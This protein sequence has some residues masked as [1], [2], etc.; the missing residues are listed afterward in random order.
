MSTLRTSLSRAPLGVHLLFGALVA[1][2]FLLAGCS[3]EEPTAPPP[4]IVRTVSVEA[5]APPTASFSGVTRAAVE[6]QVSFQ[7]GGVVTAVPVEVGD[8]VRRG[9]LL[10]RLD[11]ADFELQAQQAASAL[12]QAEAQARAAA[13]DFDR[14]RALYAEGVIPAS[15]YDNARAR[16]ETTTS[17]VAAARDQV[18]LAQR[19]LGY[20]RLGAPV[21]GRVAEVFVEAGELV[22]PG[23]PVALV[24]TEDSP[25][26][27]E[28]TVPEQ[29]IGSIQE[30]ATAA[31]S[32]AALPGD[33]FT[34]TV[35]EVGV[36]SRRTATTFPVVLRVNEAD[37]R[38]RSGKTARVTFDLSTLD[39]AE[40]QASR[41][42]VLPV[43][44]IDA[45]T[46]GTYVMVIEPV[47]ADSANATSVS[48]RS[49]EEAVVRRRAVETGTLRSDGVEVL[50]GL[51]AHEW[52]VAAGLGELADGQRVRLAD[53]DPLARDLLSFSGR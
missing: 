33:T 12:Q 36:A 51:E 21:S 8:R 23:Q 45:D 52:V 46:E 28:V 1:L 15:Q 48:V 53:Y 43:A 40:A 47:V 32:F 24:N 6:S 13:A 42:L 11:A 22:G 19:G 27:V 41:A 4:P 3:A 7:V 26:E 34:G 2:L 20:T 35:T 31:L 10:A 37:A 25:I 38:L 29:L 44:A 9:A 30:G 49:Q 18:A 5:S 17:G 39:T 50:Q 16:A 14:I